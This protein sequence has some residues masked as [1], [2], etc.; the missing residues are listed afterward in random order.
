M[1]LNIRPSNLDRVMGCP[2]S[3]QAVA[4]LG[5]Q[6]DNEFTLLGKK[7]HDGM[8]LMMRMGPE[9]GATKLAQSEDWTADD[10]TITGQAYAKAAHLL[11][12]YNEFFIEETLDLGFLKITEGERRV[13]VLG[14][15]LATRSLLILDWKFGSSEVS[16]PEWNWQLLAYAA[17]ALARWPGKI[18]TVELAI[19]QPKAWKDTEKERSCQLPAAHIRAKAIEILTGVKAAQLPNAPR[20]P[21]PK[22]CQ[23]CAFKEGCPE[24]QGELK[25]A[26][27]LAKER[28]V[29]RV[30]SGT[31]IMV[32]A[33]EGQDLSLPLVVISEELVAKVDGLVAQAAAIKVADVATANEAGTLSQKIRSLNKDIDTN[34][35]E[36]KKPWLKITK[37]IDEAPKACTNK[38]TEADNALQSQVQN[39]LTA[40]AEK[41][42]K[43]E[44]LRQQQEAAAQRAEEERQKA[45]RSRK[46]EN[47]EAH[48]QAAQEAQAEAT[49]LGQQIQAQPVAPPVLKVAGFTA[50]PTV[51]LII[52]DLGLLPPPMVRLL[53][54]MDEKKVK[55]AFEKGL[56]T[57]ATVKGWGTIQRG[58]AAARR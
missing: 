42:R 13:D 14:L 21:T 2:G 47:A 8:A 1:D 33:E 7:R 19:I 51:T 53:L 26:A 29:E 45:E 10:I 44:E 17:G 41:A 43:A 55:A 15:N 57:D 58:T 28:L 56:L 20:T 24:R 34:R 39:F 6:P 23:W 54:S 4:L 37:A 50:K 12:G 11:E 52:N 46:P 30:A 27:A 49:Q 31:A 32:Q 5:P 18:D 25:R 16:D 3:A 22:A 40:E 36:V 9:L 35:S 38:L 48:A